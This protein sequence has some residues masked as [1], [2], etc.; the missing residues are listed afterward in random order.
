MLNVNYEQEMLKLQM[1]YKL[2]DRKRKIEGGDI[3]IGRNRT[4]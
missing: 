1:E 4:I 2:E 3:F